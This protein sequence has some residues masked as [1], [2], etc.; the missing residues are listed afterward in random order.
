MPNVA[1]LTNNFQALQIFGSIQ[2]S[3]ESCVDDNKVVNISQYRSMGV[4]LY[5]LVL[6]ATFYNRE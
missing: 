4:E 2:N 5:P 1:K 3:T 6:M